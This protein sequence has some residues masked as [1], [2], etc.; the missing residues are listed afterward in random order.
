MYISDMIA[1]RMMKRRHKIKAKD[2]NSE[3][4]LFKDINEYM[5][6]WDKERNSKSSH[7]RNLKDK[8]SFINS[9][10]TNFSVL[11]DRLK[12]RNLVNFLIF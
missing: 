5:L 2:E 10:F 4:K 7:R 8:E 1:S 12:T 6:N 3:N 11:K 9:G